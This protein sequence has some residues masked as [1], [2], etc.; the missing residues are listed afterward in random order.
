MKLYLTHFLMNWHGSLSKNDV[1]DE[2]KV[3]RK[4]STWNNHFLMFWENPALTTHCQPTL[5][6]VLNNGGLS[7]LEHVWDPLRWWMQ[8]CKAIYYP[9]LCSPELL[10]WVLPVSP[11]AGNFS[12]TRVLWA[13]AVT[14]WSLIITNRLNSKVQGWVALYCVRY[15]ASEASHIDSYGPGR[16]QPGISGQQNLHCC[17]ITLLI[18][19]YS[20][21]ITYGTWG[22]TESLVA[23][24]FHLCSCDWKTFPKEFLIEFFTRLLGHQ[25]RA[26]RHNCTRQVYGPV[27][28]GTV[29]G[30][31]KPQNAPH[32][33]VP[34]TG[35]SRIRVP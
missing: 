28:M 6:P 30:P 22:N 8:R 31:Y 25:H 1:L 9:S 5:Q 27:C 20:N 21:R 32:T 15:L 18:Y 33:A 24:R 26:A 19:K 12:I 13:F 4:R 14:S 35:R 10:R 16:A 17:N 23:S 7:W 34:Y 11:P 29:T 3:P 2:L